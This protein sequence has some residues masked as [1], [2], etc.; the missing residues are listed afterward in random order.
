M[1]LRVDNVMLFVVNNTVLEPVGK[2]V[3]IW[4]LDTL[5]SLFGVAGKLVISLKVLGNSC[6]L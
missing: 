4:E 6:I 3:V 5:D 2:R 1:P